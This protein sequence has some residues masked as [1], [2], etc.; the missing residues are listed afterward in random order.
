V[1]EQAIGGEH[2]V[3][4]SAE[5]GEARSKFQDEKVRGIRSKRVQCDEIWS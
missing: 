3:K 1:V 4:L 5:L 2:V